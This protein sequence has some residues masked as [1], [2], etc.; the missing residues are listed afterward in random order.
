MQYALSQIK[1]FQFRF[2]DNFVK[3]DTIS[4]DFFTAS[5]RNKLRKRRTAYFKYAPFTCLT[6][7]LSNMLAV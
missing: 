6:V 2:C 4:I 7:Q 1:K 3:C 5:F